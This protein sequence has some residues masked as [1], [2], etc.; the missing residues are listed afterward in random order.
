MLETLD[1]FADTMV[2]IEETPRSAVIGLHDKTRGPPKIMQ[3]KEQKP[4]KI[5]SPEKRCMTIPLECERRLV[6]LLSRSTNAASE[7]FNSTRGCFCCLY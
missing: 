3:R 4:V 2:K 7:D 5:L 1:M 6:L